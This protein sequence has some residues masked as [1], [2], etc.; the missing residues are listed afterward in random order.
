[1]PEWFR[2]LAVSEQN[3]FHPLME[4]VSINRNLPSL[5]PSLIVP[6]PQLRISRFVQPVIEV[7]LRIQGHRL[8]E[9]YP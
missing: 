1:M 5:A 2:K 3:A 7:L 8:S 6:L 4:P 9:V